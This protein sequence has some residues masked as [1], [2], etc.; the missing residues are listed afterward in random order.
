MGLPKREGYLK[1]KVYPLQMESLVILLRLGSLFPQM[2][3]PEIR[4]PLNTTN[5]TKVILE[6][7]LTLIGRQ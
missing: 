6:K 5:I 2:G 1:K 7:F 3:K 4:N